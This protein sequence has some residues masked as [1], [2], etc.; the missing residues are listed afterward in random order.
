LAE[1]ARNWDKIGRKLENNPFISVI[2]AKIPG[3]FWPETG[4][5]P[6]KDVALG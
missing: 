3:H 4:P 5:I 2:P 1:L 6:E